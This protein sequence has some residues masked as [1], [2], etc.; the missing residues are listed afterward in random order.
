MSTSNGKRLLRI[1][2]DEADALRAMFPAHTYKRWEFGGSVRRKQPLVGDVE[3]IVEPEYGDV[4]VGDGLFAETRRVNLLWH[5]VDHAYK[6]NLIAKHVYP[7]GTNRWGEKYRGLSYR[8]F[9]HE[10]FLA[11]ENNWGLMLLIRTGPADF[12]R[13][14][15]TR[16][17]ANGNPSTGGYVRAS[18]TDPAT[19]PLAMKVIPCPDERTVFSLAGM[20]WQEPEARR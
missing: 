10:I 12:S 4:S 6:H 14:V 9:A 2:V 17:N 1:A 13:E 20:H 19:H 15:V 3:H 5:H 11:D 8:G 18:V 16:L 7:N